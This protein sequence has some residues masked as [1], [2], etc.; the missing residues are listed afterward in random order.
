MADKIWI[1]LQQR[2]G[3]IHR[4]SW[5]A[6]AAGQTRAAFY[7]NFIALPRV[8]EVQ[9]TVQIKAIFIPLKWQAI[10]RCCRDRRRH[11]GLFGMTQQ[12]WGNAVEDVRR[13]RCAQG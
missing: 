6:I 1:V 12:R 5:E 11:R 13:R 8:E 7:Q 9:Q 10:N 3:K 2:D 4:M